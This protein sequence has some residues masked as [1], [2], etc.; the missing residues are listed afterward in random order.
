MHRIE[1]LPEEYKQYV[2]RNQSLLHL[3]LDKKIIQQAELDL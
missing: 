1:S 2:K 3:L